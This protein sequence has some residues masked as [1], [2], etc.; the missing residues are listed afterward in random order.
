SVWAVAVLPDGRL[1]T[2]SGDNTA[3]VWAERDGRWT[4]VATLEGH[5]DSVWA[6]AVLPDGRLA[7]G[8]G[9]NTARVWNNV[10]SSTAKA[11][12]LAQRAT[13][14]CLTPSQRQQ[15]FLTP[16]PPS[17]CY[18]TQKRP[19]DIASLQKLLI[20]GKDAEA[21]AEAHFEAIIALHPDRKTVIDKAKAEVLFERGRQLLRDDKDTEAEAAFAKV[22]AFDPSLQVAINKA[23]ADAFKNRASQAWRNFAKDQSNAALLAIWKNVFSLDAAAKK[24]IK[25]DDVK[26]D[27]WYSYSIAG[28]HAQMQ[29]SAANAQPN[30][31]DRLASFAF[32]PLRI[33]KPVDFDAIDTVQAIPACQEAVKQNPEEPRYLYLLAR[34]SSR[35][36]REEEKVNKPDLAAKHDAEKLKYLQ[37][38][39]DQGYPAAFNN[40]AL[41]YAEGEGVEKDRQKANALFLER[42]NRIIYCCWVPV[43]KQIMQEQAQL[44]RDDVRLVLGALT[45]WAAAL[46]DTRATALLNQL[47]TDGIIPTATPPEPAKFKDTPPWLRW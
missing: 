5:T 1:A 4:T 2:G 19:Y 22:L 3:R 24:E 42:L 10:I 41:A 18:S 28:L 25:S 37:Q 33:A 45:P 16:T 32:D 29:I 9:D 17:W 26:T 8:S 15:F 20:E 39:M 21:E 46:G 35:A 36:A 44:N 40:M 34:A 31:C 12:K 43:A 23:K 6:V 38:A 7:T 27:Y 13:S 11:I 14:R 30:D 47:A